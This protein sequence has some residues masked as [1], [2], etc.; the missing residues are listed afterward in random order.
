MG[1]STMNYGSYSEEDLQLIFESSSGKCHLC[2]KPVRFEAYGQLSMEGAWEVDHSRPRAEGGS[3]HGNNLYPAHSTCN[4][5]RGTRSA[6]EVRAEHG[7]SR[8]PLS[9]KERKRFKHDRAMGGVA[10]GAL[11]AASFGLGP[12]GI[13]GGALLLADVGHGLDPDEVEAAA[14]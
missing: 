1:G 9:A 4:R 14:G 2:L 13:I 10:V 5:R 12:I 6:R 7:Y 8:P 3:H 11:A